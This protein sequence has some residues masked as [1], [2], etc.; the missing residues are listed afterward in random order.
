VA[1]VV[2]ERLWQTL[3]QRGGVR[4]SV[5]GCVRGC[6]LLSRLTRVDFAMERL[7][8]QS[9][10]LGR[11]SQN[12]TDVSCREVRLEVSSTGFRRFRILYRVRSGTI[13]PL[14]AIAIACRKQVTLSA[15]FEASLLLTALE[16]ALRKNREG[17]ESAFAPLVGFDFQL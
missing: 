17:G 13:N 4:G 10:C 15:W 5:R 11:N 1:E 8:T 6:G 16:S 7:T 14:E 9:H 12:G 2:A 3:W